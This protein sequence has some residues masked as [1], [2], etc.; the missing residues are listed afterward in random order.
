[1]KENVA[2]ETRKEMEV[3]EIIHMKAGIA[4]TE[5]RTKAIR[6]ETA[7]RNIE[8]LS[9]VLSKTHMKDEREIVKVMDR[10]IAVLKEI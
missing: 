9:N 7:R 8:A 10:N 4:N 3:L 1:M 6:L 5:E 2:T